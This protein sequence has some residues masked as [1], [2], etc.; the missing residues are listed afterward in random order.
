MLPG[1]AFF[2]FF[3]GRDRGEYRVTDELLNHPLK[4]KYFHRLIPYAKLDETHIV[5]FDNDYPRTITF[6]DWPQTIFL[7]ATGRKTIYQFTL[8]MARRYK[9]HVPKGL[10]RTIIEETEKLIEEKVI[11]IADE[12]VMLPENLLYAVKPKI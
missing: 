4:D 7:N 12:E 9:G 5:A 8:K 6:D 1:F 3:K 10:E 11:A 2:D